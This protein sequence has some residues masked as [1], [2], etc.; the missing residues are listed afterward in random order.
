VCSWGRGGQEQWKREEKDEEEEQLE[1]VNVLQPNPYKLIMVIEVLLPLPRALNCSKGFLP[2]HGV[3]D[4]V[5]L[6]KKLFLC[7]S[8]ISLFL[9]FFFFSFIFKIF[10]F[11]VFSLFLFLFFMYLKIFWFY[12]FF[13]NFWL[14]LLLPF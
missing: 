7:I 3:F 14:L 2:S 6:I 13:F 5:I 12:I 10:I 4:S 1:E 8:L 9:C 11:L